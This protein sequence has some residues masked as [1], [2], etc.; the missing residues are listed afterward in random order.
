MARS[1]PADRLEVRSAIKPVIGGAGWVADEGPRRGGRLIT[2]PGA[3]SHSRSHRWYTMIAA[4]ATAATGPRPHLRRPTGEKSPACLLIFPA[5]SPGRTTTTA[6]T[7]PATT[8]PAA[9]DV[10]TIETELL[11]DPGR[12]AGG[13]RLV[14]A[15]STT[16]KIRASPSIWNRSLLAS[17]A[18]IGDGDRPGDKIKGL[19][20]VNA[21]DE[22]RSIGAAM[23]DRTGRRPDARPEGRGPIRHA[24]DNRRQALIPLGRPG[25]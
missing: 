15:R 8:I 22:L 7:I 5:T 9:P 13:D 12:R 21:K 10:G 11:G 16:N 2:S 1:E 6:A 17:A 18:G 20:F 14:A 3:G 4:M 24:T 25:G 23:P 19:S